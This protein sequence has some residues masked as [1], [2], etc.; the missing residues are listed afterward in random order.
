MSFGYIK[1]MQEKEEKYKN[2]KKVPHYVPF[3]ILS[4]HEKK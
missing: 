3:F 2:N 4:S 1:D